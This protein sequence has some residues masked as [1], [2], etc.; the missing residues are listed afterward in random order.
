MKGLRDILPKQSGRDALGHVSMRHQGG[1][2]KRFYRTIDWMRDK[3]G[4]EG[5]VVS[6]EYDPNRRPTR[7]LSYADGEKRYILS[8]IG[9]SVGQQVISTDGE[10]G[11]GMRCFGQH[12]GRLCYSQR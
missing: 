9:L 2:H 5:R 7:F 8:P 3:I 6:I 4:I 11:L 12:S 10:C 1:R